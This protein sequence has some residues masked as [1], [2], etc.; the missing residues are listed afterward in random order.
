MIRGLN[1]FNCI[2]KT[3]ARTF[4]EALLFWV[5]QKFS[6]ILYKCMIWNKSIWPCKNVIT[7][8]KIKDEIRD[9]FSKC[10]CLLAFFNVDIMV[11]VKMMASRK[12]VSTWNKQS[13]TS[14][15]H[16]HWNLKIFSSIFKTHIFERNISHS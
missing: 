8:L 11:A 15:F 12:F 2:I 3:D 5:M 10:F 16:V 7:L 13:K 4:M 6:I 14:L 1:N 9:G